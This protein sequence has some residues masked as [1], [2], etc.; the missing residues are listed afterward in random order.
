M[1]VDYPDVVAHSL[2]LGRPRALGVCIAVP[3]ATVQCP[4]RD[5]DPA[6]AMG[7]ILERTPIDGGLGP[8]SRKPPSHAAEPA[9]DPTGRATDCFKEG[10][11]AMMRALYS[12]AGGMIAQQLNTD[13]TAHNLANVNTTGF[14]KYRVDFQDLMAQTIRG[15][16]ALSAGGQMVPTGLVV[17][18]GVKPAAT[19][20]DY[21]QGMFVE[22]GIPTDILIEG[23]GFFQVLVPDG[24]VAYQRDG[25][26]KL[27]ADGS[28]VTSDGYYLEPQIS[29]PPNT[30]QLTIDGSGTVT[31]MLPGNIQQNIGQIETVRFIN[32]PG[33][34]GMGK[35]LYYETP[36]SGPPITGTP[37]LEGFGTIAQ[38]YIEGSNVQVV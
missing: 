17:G 15:P 24:T 20:R 27:D 35:N 2:P 13:V 33:L 3:A 38:G 31:A 23:E 36:A 34:Q 28:M 14:K 5:I 25:A 16:G 37:G 1:L 8:L 22:T 6:T 9:T 4:Q 32:P 21:A 10:N 29:I 7:V 12:G 26:F 18:L 11:A 19:V 30:L